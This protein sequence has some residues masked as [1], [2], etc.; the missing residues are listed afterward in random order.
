[1]VLQAIM[2]SVVISANIWVLKTSI[3]CLEVLGVLDLLLLDTQ[4]P[5]VGTWLGLRFSGFKGFGVFL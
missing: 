1:M 4:T 5:T 2:C 3:G